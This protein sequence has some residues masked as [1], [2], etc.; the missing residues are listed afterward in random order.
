MPSPLQ[1]LIR[2][3]EAI[4]QGSD[5]GGNWPFSVPYRVFVGRSGGTRRLVRDPI[6]LDDPPPGIPPPPVPPVENQPPPPQE[7]APELPTSGSGVGIYPQI[8]L[9][10]PAGPDLPT[11]GQ[12]GRILSGGFGPGSSV[13]SGKLSEGVPVSIAS[14]LS[15]VGNIASVVS[16]GSDLWQATAS[17]GVR[18]F[19]NLPVLPGVAAPPQGFRTGGNMNSYVPTSSYSQQQ[20]PTGYHL[21]KDGSGR[22]VKNRR[23]NVL[24]AKAARRAIRRIKGARKMLT[25]IE[26]SLPT[27]T[28]RRRT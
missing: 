1:D 28:V 2:L 19:G 22:M 14:I 4:G 9:D 17:A 25:Q 15:R 26:R 12:I 5:S 6:R 8:D 7:D 11:I 18:N 27:R 10:S 3:F 24:N 21:A 23:M 20:C 16:A 13:G